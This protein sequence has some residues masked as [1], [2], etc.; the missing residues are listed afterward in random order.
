M[1]KRFFII[2]AMALA[3]RSYHAFAA[4]Q[5]KTQDG[6]TTSAVFGTAM[7]LHKLID[8][9]R[10]DYLAVACDSREKTFRHDIFPQ[11]KAHRKPMP[12]D[13]AEQLPAFFRLIDAFKIPCIKVAGLEADDLIGAIATQAPAD[14]LKY[15]VSGDKDFMQLVNEHTLL[16]TPKKGGESQIRDVAYIQQTFGFSPPHIIDLLAIMGDASDNV[17][18]VH[19]IGEKGATTLVQT[20]GTLENIYE[21][22]GEIA[23][24]KL[25]DKLIASR[26][27]AF[28][29]KRLVTIKTDVA[30]PWQIDD[31]RYQVEPEAST[32]LAAL[33]EELEFTTLSARIKAKHGSNEDS[34]HLTGTKIQQET[35][36]T[37]ILTQ[38][39]AVN[40]ANAPIESAPASTPVRSFD[41][42]TV[43]YQ[44]VNNKATLDNLISKLEVSER[45][46]F[47][48]ET[49]GLDILSDQPIGLSFSINSGSAFYVP[50]IEDQLDDLSVQT[51]L[52]Q[53]QPALTNPRIEKI[54]HNLKFDFQMMLNVGI[55]L[56]GPFGDSMIQSHLLRPDEGGHGLDAACLRWLDYRKITTESLFGGKGPIN[57]LLADPTD[58]KNYAC[59]DADLTLQLFERL[60]T[61][62]ERL[63][64]LPLYRDVEMPLMPILARMERRGIYL[65]SHHL[66]E[67]SNKLAIRISD[68]DARIQ[69]EAGEVFNINSPK[70]LATI[71]YD[72]LKLHE[73]LGV[74]TIKRTK[75]G[76]ST[77]VSMLEKLSASPLVKD[78]LEY[79]TLTKLKNTYTDALP[80][81]VHP[82]S[83]RLH[84]S[85][86]QT[87]TATGR[88]S[89]S[90]PNLQNIPIRSDYGREIRRAFTHEDADYC[91]VSADYS[92]IELR[93]LAHLAGEQTLTK[94]FQSAQDIHR[95]TAALVFNTPPDSV[96]ADQR[97]QAKAINF[98]LIY[99]MGATRLAQQTGIKVQEAKQFIERYFASYPQIRQFIEQTVAQARSQRFVTT[100]LGR[101]RPLFDIL[102]SNK[103]IAAGQEN[104]AVN[105]PIQGSAADL[106]KIAMIS[107]QKKLDQTG[108][109]ANMLLQVHDELIFECHKDDLRAL[110]ALAKDAMETALALD[111]PLKVDIGHGKNWLE[112]H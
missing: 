70:Q 7:F 53:L 95:E 111:V 108:L 23:N 21:N 59:E 92:Q 49:T 63:G 48:T 32:D 44:L 50:L 101:R 16:L 66:K 77:D 102:N 29:S 51:V 25:R 40:P 110:E 2:D 73:K 47:D 3:F 45:F 91:I 86:Q 81:L 98:G 106:I 35:A 10:P 36:E 19:G 74:K 72:K 8:D 56:E 37:L 41:S 82:K 15:I 20:F 103:M 11:Y 78:L 52:T 112:A 60:S 61:E 68:L 17:P 69:S 31:F 90:H 80:D 71:L 87:I 9:E 39:V 84:T 67:V 33:Y 64:L 79:R 57:M 58:L 99:G 12:E 55:Q 97:A 105:T 38:E 100:I 5:L 83:H 22:L 104:I 85:F 75:S 96:S 46:A 28:L 107:I 76:F 6:L 14:V 26:E 18:G 34:K 43:D 62:I 65:D 30:L 4:R 94:A 1:P 42:R 93:I 24:A 89:S 109:R 13:L 88:L 54:G 27:Q